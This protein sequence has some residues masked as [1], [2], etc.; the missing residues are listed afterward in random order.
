MTGVKILFTTDIQLSHILT[1]VNGFFVIQLKIRRCPMQ[2]V[3][4]ITNTMAVL[5]IMVEAYI[6]YL[7]ISLNKSGIKD[8]FTL[9]KS[10]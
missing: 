6:L 8:V 9:S 4:G 7:N 2:W 5:E 10:K 3:V 1:L